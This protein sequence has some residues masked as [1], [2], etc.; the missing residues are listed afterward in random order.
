[1]IKLCPKCDNARLEATQYEGEEIDICLECGGLWF[2]KN[3][4]NR[5]I[6]EVNDGPIGECYSEHFGEEL[7]ESEYLCPDCAKPMER[8]HLLQSY[9][10]EIDIC[11]SCDGSWIDK[12]ELKAVECSPELRKV[13]GELNQKISWKTYL[14]QFLTQMPVEYNLKP[15]ILP[16]CN[17]VIIAL[18][19]IIFSLYSF[20]DE[21]TDWVI[22]HLAMTP[23]D[24]LAG[25]EW[26]TLFTATFLHGD[27]M[28]LAGNMYFL[29]VVGDNIEDAVG[30]KKY[31]ALYVFC[32]IAASLVSFASN[33]DGLIPS[34]G[35][36]GA[37]AG[38]FGI[39]LLWFRHASLTFMIVVFQKKISP[40]LFFLIWLG[41]NLFGMV[42]AN[43]G[44]DYAAHLG[45]FFA[46]LLVA[47]RMKEQVL[48]DNPMINLLSHDAVK[49]QR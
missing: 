49:I 1:M 31:L 2:E 37:I 17:W 35:A 38:F 23:A 46:G 8:H 28:H 42:M 36:S 19:C 15:K 13:L 5:L 7:G 34:V 30:H 44:V 26:W 6:D 33:M 22:E 48:A 3:E 25:K 10:H 24:I 29:Y 45:G 11:R 47:Y 39:Y 41:F 43:Q 12:E 16:W 4:V 18:N 14:F 21:T 32:G 9:Q 27:I 20:S 40:I